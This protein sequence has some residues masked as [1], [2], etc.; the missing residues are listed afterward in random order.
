MKTDDLIDALARDTAPP[1][2]P[3]ASRRVVVALALGLAVGLFLLITIFGMRPDIGAARMPVM[4]KAMFAALAASVALPVLLQLAKPG[5]P[6]GWRLAAVGG[7]VALSVGLV[8]VALMGGDPTER[9]KL[10]MAGAFP[11]CVAIIPLLAAPTALLLA[12]L[13]RDLA[14]TDLRASGAAL[15]AVSGGVGAMV[16]AMYCPVDSVAWVVTWYSVAIALCAVL[17]AFA[18][19]RLLRW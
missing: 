13:L 12:R 17:G 19:A 6:L 15:G 8:A 2:T 5:R 11:W 14:P 16:Y 9:F 10:W 7:F 3:P 1:P 4:M 18:G